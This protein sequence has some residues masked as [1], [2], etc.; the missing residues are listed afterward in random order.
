MPTERK[1]LL[2]KTLKEHIRSI[3]QNDRLENKLLQELS[4]GMNKIM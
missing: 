2:S 3:L 1:S 4:L